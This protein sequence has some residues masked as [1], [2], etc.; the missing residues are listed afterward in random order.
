MSEGSGKWQF[1]TVGRGGEK[2][3]EGGDFGRVG[4]IKWSKKRAAV[5]KGKYDAGGWGVLVAGVGG[6]CLFCVFFGFFLR[7]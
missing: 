6:S 3:G 7:L 4:Q 1:G 2:C 5:E